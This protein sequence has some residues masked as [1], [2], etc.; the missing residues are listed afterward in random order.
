MQS[1][2]PLQGRQFFLLLCGIFL[3]GSAKT[4]EGQ[5]LTPSSTSI[6][7]G[8]VSFLGATQTVVLTPGNSSVTIS[9]FSV[10]G[11]GF[12]VTPPPNKPLPLVLNPGDSTTFTVSFAP[13]EIGSITGSVTING[14]TGSG[15]S[16]TSFVVS[17]PL[18]GTLTEGQL[19]V[20]RPRI[21]FSNLQLNTSETETETVTNNGGTIV[22]I[23]SDPTT[24]GQLFKADQS[25]VGKQ[26]G[27]GQSASFG[28][29][30]SPVSSGLKTGSLT[31]EGEAD[32]PTSSTNSTV[33]ITP[34][35]IPLSG[36]SY[37]VRSLPQCSV[38]KTNDNCKLI[39]DRA[40][41]VAPPTIQ[42]YSNKRLFLVVKNPKWFERY[43][44]DVQTNQGTLSPD[45]TSSIVQSFFPNLQKLGPFAKL[46]TPATPDPCESPAIM[47]D[48]QIQHV[49]AV[50][51]PFENCLAE[52]A[53]KAITIYSQL[54][55][56]I[57]PD[58]LTTINN[59]GDIDPSSI[60]ASIKEFI[61]TEVSVS[62]RLGAISSN[63]GLKGS[64][65]DAPAIQQLSDLQKI[66]DGVASDLLN[67]SQ[68]IEDLDDYSSGEQP[69]SNLGVTS[70]AKKT[71]STKYT[72]SNDNSKC[73][74]ITSNSDNDRVYENMVT[75]TVTYSLDTLNLV[76][77]SQQ[78]AIDPTKKKSLASIAINFADHP[79]ARPDA[80]NKH[81]VP[82]WPFTA[83]RWEASA[84]VFFSMMPNRSFSAQPSYSFTSGTPMVTGNTVKENAPVPTPLP[85]AAANYRLTDDLPG[86]WKSNIYWTAAIGVNPNTTVAEYATGFSYSYRAL[87][88]SGL[89]HFGHDIHLTQGFTTSTNLGSSFSGKIPTKSYWTEAFAFGISVRIPS[90]TG[91]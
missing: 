52:L 90:L 86:R 40:N 68:R 88:F 5:Q 38:S 31:I 65:V 12:T 32:D 27:P 62:S 43:F 46:H 4:A 17:I 83:L 21:S 82:G 51:T 42:M 8:S 71:K 56:A 53:S 7:F 10:T 80:I 78:A 34:L 35:T 58:A 70:G 85:F 59:P 18:Y 37:D 49:S 84:G 20:K 63:S 69:C 47:L 19:V 23:S 72:Q 77:N 33:P 76:S 39:I 75:R 3:L 1:F 64:A 16:A 36:S 81:E 28:V 15:G 87:M 48:P 57:T 54:E 13:T 24:D 29:I 91:R 55:P 73:L 25:V 60:Q 11:P 66:I 41:P 22:T 79:N 67:F 26:L 30:F 2:R 44:L 74:Y 14:S 50:L 9:R 61:A 6:D 89:C 45:V